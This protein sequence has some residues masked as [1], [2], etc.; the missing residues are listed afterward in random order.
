MSDSQCCF[1]WQLTTS[2]LPL[3]KLKETGRVLKF[4]FVDKGSLHLPIALL[5]FP[6]L[7]HVMLVSKRC[8]CYWCAELTSAI[9]WCSCVPACPMDILFWQL[10]GVRF[11][12][13][14]LSCVALN[15]VPLT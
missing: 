15:S 5:F 4:Q 10:A 12:L 2:F 1:R 8:L 11:E 7:E 9:G 3:L 6:S 14:S 13:G